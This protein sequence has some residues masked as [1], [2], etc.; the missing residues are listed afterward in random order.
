MTLSAPRPPQAH[1]QRRDRPEGPANQQQAFIRAMGVYVKEL[2]DI[3]GDALAR[4]K[5][6][7]EIIGQL[8]GGRRRRVDVTFPVGPEGEPVRVMNLSS[9]NT[10]TG[11]ATAT[12]AVV[13]N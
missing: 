13:V 9:R 8:F 6:A 1:D 2:A 4:G 5:P 12:G 3:V 11:I 10:V 7:E